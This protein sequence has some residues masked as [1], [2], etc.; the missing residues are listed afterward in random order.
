M[1]LTWQIHSAHVFAEDGLQFAV[2]INGPL[3]DAAQAFSA[4]FSFS[5]IGHGPRAALLN[6]QARVHPGS[7]AL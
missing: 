1:P 2:I 6:K 3:S 5:E 4:S 7:A